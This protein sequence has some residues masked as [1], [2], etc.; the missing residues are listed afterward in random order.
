[1][2]PSPA[3]VAADVSSV[4]DD[5]Y[6]EDDT[7]PSNTSSS[8]SPALIQ[9]ADLCPGQMAGESMSR[10]TDLDNADKQDGEAWESD[11]DRLL[12][13][14]IQEEGTKGWKRVASHFPGRSSKDCRER[15]DLHLNPLLDHGPWRPC[16]DRYLLKLQQRHGNRWDQMNQ[17]MPNRS[18]VAIKA[19]C[20]TLSKYVRSCGDTC[21][22]SD[23]FFPTNFL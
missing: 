23:T 18:V 8:A 10:A 9:I 16:E 1:M 15:W 20:K 19:R 6:I 17:W 3:V 5:T 7:K 11:D 13:R 14:V 2:K 12:L 4:D 21:A 22:G